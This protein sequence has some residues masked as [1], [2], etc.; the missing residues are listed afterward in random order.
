MEVKK[1]IL[2][3][4]P[5][6]AWYHIWPHLRE[7]LHPSVKSWGNWQL[8]N[9]QVFLSR[10]IVFQGKTWL[11]RGQAIQPEITGETGRNKLS[12]D[13]RPGGNVRNDR[14]GA[15]VVSLL[16]RFWLFSTA[17]LGR[18][19]DC[20]VINNVKVGFLMRQLKIDM[21]NHTQHCAQSLEHNTDMTDVCRGGTGQ[22]RGTNMSAGKKK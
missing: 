13:H 15:S 19:Y 21:W 17:S 14:P 9:S 11:D 1:D 8:K 5:K 10:K 20:Y 16:F 4:G 3:G 2:Y 6:V 22:D 18:R 12:P 7:I